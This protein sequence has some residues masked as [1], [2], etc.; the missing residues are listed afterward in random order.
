MTHTGDKFP[1]TVFLS[2]M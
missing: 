1:E 2:P